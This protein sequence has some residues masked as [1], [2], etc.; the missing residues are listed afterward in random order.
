MKY[1]LQKAKMAFLLMTFKGHNAIIFLLLICKFCMC[2]FS[3]LYECL[4]VCVFVCVCILLLFCLLG[5][6]YFLL[7]FVWLFI[8]EKE[9]G[10]H[11]PG[12]PGTRRDQSVSTSRVLSLKVYTTT[13]GPCIYF[14]EQHST[15]CFHFTCRLGSAIQSLANLGFAVKVFF[16]VIKTVIIGL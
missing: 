10:S 15:V 16:V 3:F 4:C 11:C 13:L 6:A 9:S 5:G 2:L 1:Q 8:L 7:L 14:V 12:W